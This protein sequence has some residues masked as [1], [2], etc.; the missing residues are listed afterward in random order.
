[1]EKGKGMMKGIKEKKDNEIKDL[2]DD[3][4]FL[5]KR[6]A[7]EEEE[8]QR[9]GQQFQTKIIEYKKKLQAASGRINTL[10]TDVDEF[11]D[12]V[13]LLEREK[14]KLRE[15]NDRYRRQLGGRS[16][17]DTA[18]QS[19][20][21]TLQNEFKNAIEE[22]RELKRKLQGQDRSLHSIGDDSRSTPYSRTRGNQSTLLQL[23]AE[24]EE[25][26]ESL[27][28]E[29]RELIMKNSAA[30]TDVQK[31]EKRAWVVEQDNAILKQDVTS[32]KLANER[33]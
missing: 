19:Q 27:N 4:H 5:E 14:F 18:L 33:L 3:I 9:L 17:S 1:M 20:V 22:N 30:I 12:R 15:E 11:E 13:K 10:S 2:T 29:K 7:G 16:G 8:K 23:R 6:I 28:D 25:T 32:L 21:E 24:Y 26:I 31:A